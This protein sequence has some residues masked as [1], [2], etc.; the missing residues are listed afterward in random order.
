MDLFV[1]D[2]CTVDGSINKLID[3]AKAANLKFY[4]GHW[5]SCICLSVP[6]REEDSKVVEDLLKEVGFTFNKSKARRWVDQEVHFS[7]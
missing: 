2:P 5:G 7:Y 6:E 4:P 1:I 3:L